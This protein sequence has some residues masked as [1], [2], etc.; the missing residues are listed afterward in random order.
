MRVANNK[1]SETI[2]REQFLNVT[3]RWLVR[4]RQGANQKM[5]H[6]GP[7]WVGLVEKYQK[8]AMVYSIYF[9]TPI[10]TRAREINLIRQVILFVHIVGK[11][12]CCAKLRKWHCFVLICSFFFHNDVWRVFNDFDTWLCSLVYLFSQFFSVFLN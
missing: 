12:H 6:C 10:D 5:S 7:M 1:K 8:S 4:W 9:V 2:E 3:C 11:R